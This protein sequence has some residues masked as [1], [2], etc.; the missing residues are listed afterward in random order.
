MEW[1]VRKKPSSGVRVGW[2]FSVSKLQEDMAFNLEGKM[3]L[4]FYYLLMK[5]QED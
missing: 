5:P 4:Y 3:H 1:A 2:K